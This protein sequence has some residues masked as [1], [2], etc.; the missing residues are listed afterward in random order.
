MILTRLRPTRIYTHALRT[1]SSVSQFVSAAVN[2]D[3][4]LAGASDK[5]KAAIT[6]LEAETEG[7]AKDLSVRD[8]LFVC[9]KGDY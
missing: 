8:L 2:A 6:Q 7:L 5:D 4:S 1:M 3:P 9:A